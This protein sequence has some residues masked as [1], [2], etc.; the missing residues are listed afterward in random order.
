MKPFLLVAI[1]AIP[2]LA[3]KEREWKTAHVLDS[4]SRISSYVTGS[5]T[6]TSGAPDMSRTDLE[7][8][9]VKASELLLAGEGYFYVIEDQRMQAGSPLTK[10]LANRKHG[11]RFVVGEDVKYAQEKGDLWVLD[12]DGKECKVTILK[13]QKRDADAKPVGAK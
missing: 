5:T 8:V 1:A 7:R 12:E 4:R 9:T 2:L 3:A 13:Q 10:A 11:C 6:N